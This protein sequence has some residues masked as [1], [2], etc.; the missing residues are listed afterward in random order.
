[1]LSLQ[2]SRCKTLICNFAIYLLK[3]VLFI[4]VIQTQ[5]SC[6]YYGS[7]A[8]RLYQAKSSQKPYHSIGRKSLS[9]TWPVLSLGTKSRIARDNLGLGLILCMIY[10][11]TYNYLNLS[12]GRTYFWA[13]E[14][15]LSTTICCLSI[16]HRKRLWWWTVS[17]T[18]AIF[19]FSYCPFLCISAAKYERY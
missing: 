9:P 2:V 13:Y 19:L 6:S 10:K 8:R 3:Y 12:W 1:M 5:V 16:P 11:L 7:R 18:I 4:Y 14:T 15:E 17:I